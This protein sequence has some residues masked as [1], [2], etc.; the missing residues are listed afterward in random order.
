VFPGL[1]IE[2][3]VLDFNLGKAAL[4]E[5]DFLLSVKMKI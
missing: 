1:S 5:L 3:F 4:C 2:P